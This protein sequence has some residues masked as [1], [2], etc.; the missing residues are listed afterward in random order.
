M[1]QPEINHGN[2]TLSTYSSSK[3]LLII[4][5]IDLWSINLH[6]AS[7]E[8]MQSS[9]NSKCHLSKNEKNKTHHNC[10]SSDQQ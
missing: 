5:C 8:P 9:D 3:Q 6:Q 1:Y 4:V 2:L 10:L 7:L